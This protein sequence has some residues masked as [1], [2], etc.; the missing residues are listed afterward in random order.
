[1]KLSD[2]RFD[3]AWILIRYVR[4]ELVIGFGGKSQHLFYSQLHNS[5][6]GKGRYTRQ[7]D[8]Q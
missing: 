8:R 7:I 5:K 6:T 4:P 2:I 3:I 1:M